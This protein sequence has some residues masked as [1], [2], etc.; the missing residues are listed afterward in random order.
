MSTLAS[1][2]DTPA[3]AAS[4]T[5]RH[6]GWPQPEWCY[7]RAMIREQVSSSAIGR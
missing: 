2:T 6:V 3:A 7:R 5:V 1:T 4:Y